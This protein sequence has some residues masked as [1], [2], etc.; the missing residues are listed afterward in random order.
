ML[1]PVAAYNGEDKRRKKDVSEKKIN[2]CLRSEDVTRSLP[3]GTTQTKERRTEVNS[4]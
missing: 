4:T 2:A 3:K 1:L